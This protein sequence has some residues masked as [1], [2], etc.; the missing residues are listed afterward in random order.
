MLVEIEDVPRVMEVLAHAERDEL[1]QR[2]ED[3]ERRAHG[4]QIAQPHLG[5]RTARDAGVVSQAEGEGAS[6]QAAEKAAAAALLERLAQ[7]DTT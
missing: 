7:E 5:A 2:L 1:E 3:E 4:V 6:K